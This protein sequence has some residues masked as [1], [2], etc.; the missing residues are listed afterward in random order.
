MKSTTPHLDSEDDFEDIFRFR[1]VELY[2][3][4]SLD[5][6]VVSLSTF[7]VRLSWIPKECA[8]LRHLRLSVAVPMHGFCSSIIPMVVFDV[9]ITTL[10]GDGFASIPSQIIVWRKENGEVAYT[11]QQQQREVAWET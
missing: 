4:R 3:K 10:S 7:A 2:E 11:K 8:F 5:C 6:D 9:R 1:V